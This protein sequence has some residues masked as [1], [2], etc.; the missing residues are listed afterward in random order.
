MGKQSLSEGYSQALVAFRS[1]KAEDETLKGSGLVRI[2]R[3]PRRWAA[4]ELALL[5]LPGGDQ[6]SPRLKAAGTAAE[7]A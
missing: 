5:S 2:P 7:H 6:V 4:S 3:T 1:L